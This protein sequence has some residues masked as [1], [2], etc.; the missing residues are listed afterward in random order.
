MLVVTWWWCWKEGLDTKTMD[1]WKG[2]G[3]IR[4]FIYMNSCTDTPRSDFFI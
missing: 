3:W 4:Y 1:G 2:L